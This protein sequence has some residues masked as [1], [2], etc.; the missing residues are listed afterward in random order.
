MKKAG[1]F[2]AMTVMAVLLAACSG[3]KLLKD[4]VSSEYISKNYDGATI[5]FAGIDGYMFNY[6]K[7]NFRRVV[8]DDGL[9]SNA[10]KKAILKRIE[11]SEY[12]PDRYYTFFIRTHEPYLDEKLRFTFSITDAG[13]RQLLEDVFLL[14]EKNVIIGTRMVGGNEFHQYIWLIKAKK[15]LNEAHVKGVDA[16]IILKITFPNG[17]SR[18]YSMLDRLK[19]K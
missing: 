19:K 16:P 5:D 8:T 9:I 15:P 2:V 12:E 14:D 6:F 7:E 11:G 18:T 1:L 4:D 3:M 17:S 10:Q 13:N